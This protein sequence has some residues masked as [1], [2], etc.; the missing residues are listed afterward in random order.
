MDKC[1]ECRA[2]SLTPFFFPFLLPRPAPCPPTPQLP[3]SAREE[4]YAFHLPVSQK[5]RK[6]SLHFQSSGYLQ[7]PPPWQDASNHSDQGVRSASR[8]GVPVA[9]GYP[10]RAVLHLAGSGQRDHGNVGR[11]NQLL[12]LGGGVEILCSTSLDIFQFLL[13]R[14][15]V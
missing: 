11:R 3:G 13:G 8:S 12:P 14:Q 1:L 9:P 2:K 4:C 10:L 7:P 15:T 6:L 5:A